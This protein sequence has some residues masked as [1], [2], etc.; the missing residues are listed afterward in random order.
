MRTIAFHTLGCKVNQYDA[1]AMRELFLAAGYQEVAHGADVVLVNTCTVTATGDRKS[2]Q[3]LRRAVRENPA[4]AVIAAGCL[5]QRAPEAVAL[6][7][8]RLVIGTQYRNRVVELLHEALESGGVITAVDALDNTPYEALSVTA[9]EGRSRAVLK[10]QEGCDAHCAYCIIPSVRGSSRSRPL[11]DVAEEARKLAAAGY[12]E[13]VLTGIQLT[14]Y[15]RDLGLDLLDA[16]RAVAEAGIPRVRLGSLEPPWLTIQRIEEMAAIPQLVRAFHLSLQSGCAQTVRRMGR[17]YDPQQLLGTLAHLF[18]TMPD[19]A[20]RA[21]VIVGFPG[22]TDEEHR[23]SMDMIGRAGF[24]GLHVF[25]YSVR[26]GTPAA[27]MPQ[28]PEDIK[29]KRAADMNALAREL[30]RRAGSADDEEEA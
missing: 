11:A 13:A 9:H 2:R 23:L 25:P 19:A 8:V 14:G 28:V 21:D 20:M 24:A 6:P 3:A 29:N 10:I 17:S 5:A 22:E 16:V 7:G 4:C 27:A 18:K 30:A 1:Q 26:Q 12:E 15:G